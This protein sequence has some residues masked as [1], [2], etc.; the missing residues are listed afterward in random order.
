MSALS[1]PVKNP[2]SSVG[3]F[4]ESSGTISNLL[5]ATTSDS[6]EYPAA[7]QNKKIADKKD[8][9]IDRWYGLLTVVLTKIKMNP[10]QVGSIPLYTLGLETHERLEFR[11]KRDCRRV[12]SLSSFRLADGTFI[13]CR[14]LVTLSSVFLFSQ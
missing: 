10:S 2:D 7:Q 3:R 12:Q 9:E 4:V 5:K 6:F 14:V 8:V 11:V 1:R 13:A